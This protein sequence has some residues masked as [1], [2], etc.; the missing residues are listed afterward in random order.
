MV[1]Q[2]IA[3]VVS[4]QVG[5]STSGNGLVENGLGAMEDIY[6]TINPVG[7]SIIP[8]VAA[9]WWQLYHNENFW[10]GEISKEDPKYK[11]FDTP[12]AFQSK[13]KTKKIFVDMAEWMNSA[14]GGD[15][16]TP[17]SLQ[18]MIDP[19]HIGSSEDDIQWGFSGS[20]LEH[21]F[22][23]YAG[24]LG[25]NV[26]QLVSGVYSL[27]DGEVN[28]AADIN[29]GQ[30]PLVS[31][32]F[33]DEPNQSGIYFQYKRLSK[34]AFQAQESLE[35]KKGNTPPAEYRKHYTE[36]K[37]LGVNVA[38]M[39]DE[40]E[41]IRKKQSDLIKAIQDN[42]NLSSAEKL[43]KVRPLEKQRVVRMRKILHYANKHNIDV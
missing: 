37:I 1:G 16:V 2:K 42:P 14:M 4:G 24:G 15:E 39:V 3:N 6:S 22:N 28:E 11:K 20:D 8:S 12:Q 21:L 32:V 26:S 30:I 43:D 35:K 31:K 33:N 23:A 27:S 34:M 41:K 18:R 19:H 5:L 10:G 25:K 7:K 40:Y 13:F 36:H 38:N 9:P 17:G 29:W